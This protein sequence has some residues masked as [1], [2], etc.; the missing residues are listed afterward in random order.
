[1]LTR[2]DENVRP[3]QLGAEEE[4]S[5][6]S[7]FLF[8]RFQ[9]FNV[10]SGSLHS[11]SDYAPVRGVVRTGR[12]EPAPQRP[13]LAG[14][15]RTLESELQNVVVQPTGVLRGCTGLL[16]EVRLTSHWAS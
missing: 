9:S 12:I 5:F 6:R 15:G 13:E 3:A 2:C 4:R 1:V 16:V 14:S 11:L 7:H 10:L 8:E